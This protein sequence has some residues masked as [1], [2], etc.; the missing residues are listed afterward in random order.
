MKVLYDLSHWNLPDGKK[1]DYATVAKNADGIILKCSDPEMPFGGDYTYAEAFD[2]FMGVNLPVASYHFHDPSIGPRLNVDCYAKYRK[3]GGFL[4]ALDVE[5]Q[6]SFSLYQLTTNVVNTLAEMAQRFGR[7]P[8]LYANFD[9][10]NYRLTDYQG[11]AANIEGFW[12]AWPAPA[13]AVLP[14]P[15]HYAL[16]A[17][18]LWQRRWTASCPGIPDS[19]LDY[20]EFQWSDERWAALVGL[21]TPPTVEEILADHERRIAALEAR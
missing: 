8:W 5:D 10:L 20:N 15:M 9:Y 1:Y 12:V 16:A 6:E 18:G 19:T 2:G 21:P 13:Y 14:K 11:I 17:V 7:K 3:D 4:D